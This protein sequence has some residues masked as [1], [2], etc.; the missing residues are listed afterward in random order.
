M[1][2]RK[3]VNKSLKRFLGR[4]TRLIDI[5]TPG[6]FALKSLEAGR[7]SDAELES[8]RRI[9][10]RKLNRLGKLEFCVTAD[11]PVTAKPNEVRM[12][13]GKGIFSHYVAAVPAGRLI[14]RI[15]GISE[16]LAKKALI[17]GGKKLSLR[18]SFVIYNC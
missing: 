9:I 8:A 7:I 2:I 16:F 17:A 14:F 6:A 4:A 12:G 11:L 18:T 13:K 5:D 3:K 1:Q 15:T 10:R